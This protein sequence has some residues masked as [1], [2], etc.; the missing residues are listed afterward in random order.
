[1]DPHF[2]R[3]KCTKIAHFSI[4]CKS[5]ESVFA[6]KELVASAYEFLDR[7]YAFSGPRPEKVAPAGQL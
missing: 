5:S 3:A 2:D 4:D 1:M 7:Y 6:A